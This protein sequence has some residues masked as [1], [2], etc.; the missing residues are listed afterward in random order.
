MEER[1]LGEEREGGG[2]DDEGGLMEKRLMELRVLSGDEEEEEGEAIFCWGNVF[3]LLG[4]IYI[5]DLGFQNVT[6]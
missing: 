3:N 2:E 1:E 4:G 6:S 5:E